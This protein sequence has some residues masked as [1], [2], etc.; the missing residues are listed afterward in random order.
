MSDALQPNVNNPAISGAPI[1]MLEKF[2]AGLYEKLKQM[3]LDGQ[4]A[5]ASGTEPSE[6]THY[7][8][9]I[10]SSSGSSESSAM[11]SKQVISS[12]LYS[13]GARNIYCF[14]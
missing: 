12:M 7:P 6:P 13:Y 10:I 4:A 14:A 2:D 11:Q 5:I 8:L 3:E 1:P 9:L